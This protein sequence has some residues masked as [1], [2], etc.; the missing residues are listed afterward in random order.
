MPGSPKRRKLNGT[1]KFAAVILWC[2]IVVLPAIAHA[3]TNQAP[4][5]GIPAGTITEAGAGSLQMLTGDSFLAAQS[6]A[7]GT[8]H[9][10][11]CAPGP[12]DGSAANPYNTNTT[13]SPQNNP[14]TAGGSIQ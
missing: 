8:V 9:V 7:A 1:R 13:V 12:G 4:G 6:A 5:A 3:V 11:A 14:N 10:D 2:T